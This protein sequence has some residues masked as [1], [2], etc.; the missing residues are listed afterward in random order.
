MNKQADNQ[1]IIDLERCYIDRILFA[2][3]YD[4][5]TINEP[6]NMIEYYNPME[7]DYALFRLDTDFTIENV[8]R[9]LFKI[10]TE[11]AKEAGRSEIQRRGRE[12]LNIKDQ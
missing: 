7:D 9:R 1:K 6:A 11:N 4:Q 3:G 8:V 5:A 10:K 12:L 2:L